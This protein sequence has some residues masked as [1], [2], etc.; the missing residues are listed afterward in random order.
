MKREAV[1]LEV[2]SIRYVRLLAFG[3]RVVHESDEVVDG[4]LQCKHFL[5]KSDV[6]Q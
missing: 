3:A 5:S 1:T 6:L 4:R 2:R